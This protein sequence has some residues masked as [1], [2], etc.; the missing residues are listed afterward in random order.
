MQ[1]VNTGTGRNYYLTLQE[2]TAPLGHQQR[3]PAKPQMPSLFTPVSGLCWS[4]YSAT[5]IQIGRTSTRQPIS[6]KN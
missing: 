6:C 5:L 4:P 3:T 2:C 1:A